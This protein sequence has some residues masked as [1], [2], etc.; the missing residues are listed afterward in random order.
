MCANV[1]SA[2]GHTVLLYTQVGTKTTEC[3]RKQTEKTGGQHGRSAPPDSDEI[4]VNVMTISVCS[5]PGCIF[6]KEEKVKK[7]T[8]KGLS[9]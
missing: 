4:H 8:K 9:T 3:V 5:P 6:V 1:G 2:L 7:K